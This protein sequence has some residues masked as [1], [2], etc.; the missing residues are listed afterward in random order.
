MAKPQR[1]NLKSGLD[2]SQKKAVS[3]AGQIVTSANIVGQCREVNSD[4]DKING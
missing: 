4:P 3:A 2:T 1:P